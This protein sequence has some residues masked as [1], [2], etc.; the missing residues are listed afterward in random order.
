MTARTLR[1]LWRARS[2]IECDSSGK[3]RVARLLFLHILQQP[4]GIVHEFRRMNQYGILGR[5]LPEFG[6]HRRPDAA[7][8]VPRLHRRPAHP[9]GA[10]QPAAL[11][12]ARVRARVSA[13]QRADERLRAPLAAVRRRALPRHR[14]GPRRRPLDARRGGRAPLLPRATAC[15]R[16]TR[17]L[18]EFLVEHHLAMSHVAQKQDVYD[19]EVMQRVRRAGRHRAPPGRALPPHRGRHARHQPEGVERVEGQAARGPVP[20]HAPRA[21]PASRSRATPRSPR[22]RPRRAPAAALRAVRRRQG[23]ALGAASTPPTSCATTRRRSPGR[24]AT[25]TTASTPTSRWSRRASR[26]SAKACR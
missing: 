2:L 13:V 22:S 25:C 10:A 6:T 11:H 20:R 7:R 16:R 1:A 18:V 17:E 15:R 26:R 5:Y 12:H 3:T 9:D 21:R 19:P 24:R 4:R 8:P 14:Q 23:Q